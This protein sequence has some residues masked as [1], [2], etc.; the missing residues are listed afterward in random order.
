MFAMQQN[1]DQLLSES[2]EGKGVSGRVGGLQLYRSSI[3][4]K[5]K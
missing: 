2:E 1:A 4:L 3:L 5:T